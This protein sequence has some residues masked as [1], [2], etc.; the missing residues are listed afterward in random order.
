MV[1]SSYDFF[2]NGHLDTESKAIL[3]Y[4]LYSESSRITGCKAAIFT[5]SSR[6][7]RTC[8]SCVLEE[9]PAF[10]R[11][12]RE[13]K[14]ENV[15]HF[16][17]STLS[18]PYPEEGKCC[19]WCPNQCRARSGEPGLLCRSQISGPASPLLGLSRVPQYLQGNKRTG[20]KSAFPSVH[21][22]P[23]HQLVSESSNIYH[24]NLLCS[25]RHNKPP[26]SFPLFTWLNSHS[27]ELKICSFLPAAAGCFTWA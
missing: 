13:Q 8:S 1:L 24:Y 5:P 22:I 3:E 19:C 4:H 14:N 2:L 18:F 17:L 6:W 10:C 27:R 9:H 26:L 25:L 12:D 23:N 20:N 7:R 21:N 15:E 16:V 11:M